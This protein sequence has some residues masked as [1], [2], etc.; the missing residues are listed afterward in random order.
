[1]ISG[2]SDRLCEKDVAL[3]KQVSPRLKAAIRGSD[4]HYLIIAKD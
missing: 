3:Q 1:M 2:T 4:I